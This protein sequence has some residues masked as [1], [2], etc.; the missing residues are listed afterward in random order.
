MRPPRGRSA[1]SGPGTGRT[2]SPPAPSRPSAASPRA[3]TAAIRRR[4]YS[5]RCCRVSPANGADSSIRGR[6]GDTDSRAGSVMGCS[7][8]TQ[9]WFFRFS[10][11]RGEDASTRILDSNM[12]SNWYQ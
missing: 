12:L 3:G 4:R 10:A 8:G 1:A 6:A 2:R 7:P 5:R 11:P 9:R